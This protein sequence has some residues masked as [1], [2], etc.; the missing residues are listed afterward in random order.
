MLKRSVHVSTCTLVGSAICAALTL[1]SNWRQ[2]PKDFTEWTSTSETMRMKRINAIQPL[3]IARLFLLSP[4]LAQFAPQAPT[5][6][7]TLR[8]S[9]GAPLSGAQVGIVRKA[10][11]SVKA[12]GI[13]PTAGLAASR[14]TDTTGV[15]QVPAKLNGSE[16][17]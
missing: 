15:F 10:P 2:R 12:A 13:T 8:G 7:G 3:M 11:T 14:V 1:W 4:L 17:H 6:T 9:T 16:R 5:I